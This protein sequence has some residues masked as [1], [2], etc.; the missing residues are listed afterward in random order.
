M[1]YRGISFSQDKRVQTFVL[2]P[3]SHSVILGSPRNAWG[4]ASVEKKDPIS[5]RL[6]WFDSGPL[7][8]EVIE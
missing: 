1:A 3:W 8:P 6:L 5:G 4:V 2:L 7:V